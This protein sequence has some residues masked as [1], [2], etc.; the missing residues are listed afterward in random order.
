MFTMLIRSIILNLC[1]DFTLWVG[2]P[3][4]TKHDASKLSVKCLS[5]HLGIETALPD[6]HPLAFVVVYTENQKKKNLVINPSNQP[7]IL[8]GDCISLPPKS[9]ILQ[10]IIFTYRQGSLRSFFWS[11]Y[12]TKNNAWSFK[13]TMVVSIIVLYL[14]ESIS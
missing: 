1:K 11:L 5:I 8:H 7:K 14:Y 10:D 6:L 13:T 9:I 2:S 12:F 4:P 3:L